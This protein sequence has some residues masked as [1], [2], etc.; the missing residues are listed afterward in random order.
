[1]S[2][3]LVA[4]SGGHL[5]ELHHLTTRLDG[6]GDVLWVT[7]DSGQS[8]TLLGGERVAYV[9]FT[10]S[11]DYRHVA[12]NTYTA[13]RILRRRGIDR[14]VSTGAAIAL[15]FLPLARARGISA[16]YIESAARSTG[17]SY[18]G[19][20]LAKVP[21]MDLYT[22]YA[23]G[24]DARWSYGGSVFDGFEPGG[25]STSSPVIRRAVVTLGAHPRY[26]F[27]RLL[28][29]L[30]AIFPPEVEVLW[31]TGVTPTDGL[32]IEAR[33]TVPTAELK[34]ALAEADV[35]VSHAGIGS[36][37]DALDAGCKPLLV[38]R[39]VVHHEHVDDHQFELVAV[40]AGRGIALVRTVEELG[41][42][43]LQAAAAGRVV[44]AADP[45]RFALS[46]F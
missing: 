24:T 40:L 33:P 42:E 38:P 41:P 4:S 8:R 34:A 5:T 13:A 45:P 30:V 18:T 46:D 6:L 26:S 25:P 20:M 31:Q 27:R 23:G 36:A 22:Q 35:V 39:S 2:T 15:S 11:R 19:S 16:H 12:M 43:H 14:V 3:L 29:R 9:P 17:R 21:G 10:G 37:L 7:F 28:E 44:R 1:M 32:G